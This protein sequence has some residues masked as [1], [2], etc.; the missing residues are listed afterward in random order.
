MERQEAVYRGY[1]IDGAFDERSWLVRV[2]PFRPDLP[3]LK[4]ATFRVVGS[5]DEACSEARHRISGVL[6]VGGITRDRQS[7]SPEGDDHAR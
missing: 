4:F 2:Q 1:R 5:W 6:T 7:N 3:I